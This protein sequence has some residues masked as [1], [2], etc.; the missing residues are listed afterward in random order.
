[1]LP[2]GSEFTVSVLWV[3]F[4]ITYCGEP[5]GHGRLRSV[6]IEVVQKQVIGIS[7]LGAYDPKGRVKQ[8]FLNC[9]LIITYWS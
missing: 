4:C 7:A 6:F 8:I 2:A 3:D 5:E 1:M 9:W